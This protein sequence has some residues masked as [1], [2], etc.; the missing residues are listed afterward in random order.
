[1][2]LELF[3]DDVRI[4][5]A[6]FRDDA[7]HEIGH[8]QHVEEEPQFSSLLQNN[9]YRVIIHLDDKTGVKEG[10]GGGGGGG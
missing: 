8:R 4:E 7:R 10:A 9:V 3:W 5:S 2:R 6:E 1:M